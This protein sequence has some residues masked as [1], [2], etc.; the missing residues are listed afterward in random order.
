MITVKPANIDGYIAHFPQATQ[1]AMQQIRKAILEAAPNAKEVISYSMPAFKINKVLVY[2]AGY[3]KHIGFY[4]AA[5]A[6]V[7]FKDELSGY[8]FAKGSIQFPLDKPMPLDLVK[9]ITAYRVT[10]DATPK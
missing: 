3:E 10:A 5:A 1:Q 9:R 6:I 2:F 8:K 7:A 4:P